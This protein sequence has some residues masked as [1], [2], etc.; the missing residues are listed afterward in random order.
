MVAG[1]DEKIYDGL[2]EALEK[3]VSLDPGLW[4]TA[5]QIA[6]QAIAKTKEE[7]WK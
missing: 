6:S 2:L 4:K 1:Q 7:V 3:I 5:Q